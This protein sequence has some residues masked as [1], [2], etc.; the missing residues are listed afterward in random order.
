MIQTLCF[1]ASHGFIQHFLFLVF[2]SLLCFLLCFINYLTQ[3]APL[4]FFSEAVTQRCFVKKVLL[5]ISQNSQ[6]NAC[7]RASFA[8]LR[9]KKRLWYRCFPV[10]FVKFLRAPFLTEQ[11]RQLLLPFLSVYL[12]LPVRFTLRYL[13]PSLLYWEVLFLFL[14]LYLGGFFLKK[15][16]K[17]KKR[18]EKKYIYR[19]S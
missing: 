9:L 12:L 16:K 4:F 5:E 1:S 11:L 15:K 7:G 13:P 3:I 19:K 8:D 2:K 14:I 18:K 6:E 17:T 10:N